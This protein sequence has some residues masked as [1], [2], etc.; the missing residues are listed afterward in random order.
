VQPRT[1][2]VAEAWPI[3]RDYPVTAGKSIYE[4]AANEVQSDRAI[5]MQQ[6]DR[7]AFTVF[8]VM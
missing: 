7:F 3:E 1:V 2:A 8:K 5:T 6:H 4:P